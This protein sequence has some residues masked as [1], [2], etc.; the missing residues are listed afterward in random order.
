MRFE[1]S[2]KPYFQ[3]VDIPDIDDFSFEK[4]SV[5]NY[6]H[7]LELFKSDENKFVDERFKNEELCKQY[8]DTIENYSP[9]SPKHG[10]ADW[11]W[12]IGNTYA[13]ILHLYDLS[14]E[15]FAENNQRC[16]IGFATRKYFRNKG[17]TVKVLK[18]FINHIFKGYPHINYIHAMT[19]PDNVASQNLLLKAGF[20]F[21]SAERVSKVHLFYELTRQEFVNSIFT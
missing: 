15:T 8:A 7:L 17:L 6:R 1:K 14:L 3:F 13:G 4:L 5:R 20:H 21:D 9:Y 10:G 12:K 2:E 18:H 16:W 19:E 11:L